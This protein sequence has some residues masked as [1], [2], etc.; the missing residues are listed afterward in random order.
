[1][2]KVKIDAGDS[3]SLQLKVKTINDNF[4]GVDA[5]ATHSNRTALDAVSGVNHG[6][7]DLTGLVHSNRTALDAV[8]GI[9][10]GDQDLTGLV[11]SNRSSLDLV[12]GTNTG[13]ST[14]VSVPTTAG[15]SGK[16]GDMAVD[17][18]YLYIC[19]ATDSWI[20]VLREVF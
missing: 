18:N 16:Q 1:M 15:S 17:S 20:K 9:N 19:I 4:S 13:N 11:H 12:S 6:D 10:Q 8:S 5:E 2:K 7:Q 3:L 14:F